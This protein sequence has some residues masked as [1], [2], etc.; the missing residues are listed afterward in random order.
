MPE[1][2]ILANEVITAAN[3]ADAMR[4][5]SSSYSDTALATKRLES[6]TKSFSN[7][8]SKAIDILDKNNLEARDLR[9]EIEDL[10]KSYLKFRREN[11]DVINS[12]RN[13]G[14]AVET[15]NKET[16]KSAYDILNSGEA[17][18][19]YARK[20]AE[21]M[22]DSES[23][24]RSFT[25]AYTDFASSLSG[26]QIMNNSLVSTYREY[27][28]T[29]DTLARS[30][31]AY[32]KS[33]D[34]IDLSIRRLGETTNLSR[35]E[36]ADIYATVERGMVGMRNYEAIDGLIERIAKLGHNA[37]QTK[38]MIQ[39]TMN[40][41]SKFG[42]TN[43]SSLTFKE[44]MSLSREDYMNAL[45]VQEGR[46]E[47]FKSKTGDFLET[48]QA[49]KKRFDDMKMGMGETI[50]GA[51]SSMPGGATG[52]VGLVGALAVLTQ[53]LRAKSLREGLSG[54]VTFNEAAMAKQ[55]EATAV[56]NAATLKDTQ[57]K[58]A[59]AEVTRRTTTA[60]AALGLAAEK[61]AA[62]LTGSGGIGARS[63]PAVLPP[64]S[65]PTTTM[66]ENKALQASN[67]SMDAANLQMQNSQTES[68]NT[69][70]M[71]GVEQGILKSSL[72]IEQGTAKLASGGKFSG[73]INS[74]MGGGG[75]FGNN[76]AMFA[77]AMAMMLPMVASMLTKQM[78]VSK[79]TA[80]K[81][82]SA[83]Q[84]TMIAGMVSTAIIPFLPPKAKAY[85]GAASAVAMGV[86]AIAGW[87]MG[88][89]KN[90][91][92]AAETQRQKEVN[93][94]TLQREEIVAKVSRGESTVEGIRGDITKNV[95]EYNS[96]LAEGEP[97]LSV[98]SVLLSAL[99]DKAAQMQIIQERVNNILNTRISLDTELLNIGR[100][101]TMNAS[102]SIQ[103]SQDI[104]KSKEMEYTK[105][106]EMAADQISFLQQ[107]QQVYQATLKEREGLSGRTDLSEEEKQTE[108]ERLDGKI[109]S[110]ETDAKAI[111][112]DL[113]KAEIGNIN[114]DLGKKAY[115]LEKSRNDAALSGVRTKQEGIKLDTE[116]AEANERLSQASHMGMGA[117]VGFMQ[118]T[119]NQY[120][121]G[122][123]SGMEAIGEMKARQQ[124]LNAEIQKGGLTEQEIKAK[125]M[126][127][128]KL[129]RDIQKEQISI[130]NQR[131][132]GL[133]KMNTLRDKYV[134]ALPEVGFAGFSFDFDVSKDKGLSLFTGQGWKSPLVGGTRGGGAATPTGGYSAGGYGGAG[135]MGMDLR[136][137][138]ASP[139]QET[140][141]R[142]MY[143]SGG[144]IAGEN[145]YVPIIGHGG[146]F[147]VSPENKGNIKK[148]NANKNSK[149]NDVFSNMVSLK[150][151]GSVPFVDQGYLAGGENEP[152]P[153]YA[154]SGS[155]MLNKKEVEGGM[156]TS[157]LIKGKQAP[158]ISRSG[159]LFSSKNVKGYAEGS[160][161][162]GP[163]GRGNLDVLNSFSG[164]KEFWDTGGYNI[165]TEEN[166]KNTIAGSLTDVIVNLGGY[167]L[168]KRVGKNQILSN[169]EQ[170]TEYIIRLAKKGKPIPENLVTM[171]EQHMGSDMHRIGQLNAR[172]GIEGVELSTISSNLSGSLE[173]EEGIY[174]KLKSKP[175]TGMERIRAFRKGLTPEQVIKQFRST[176]GKVL[177]DD[178]PL[179][180]RLSL[181]RLNPNSYENT[182]NSLFKSEKGVRQLFKGWGSPQIE[183]YLESIEKAGGKIPPNLLNNVDSM[184]QK[185]FIAEGMSAEQASALSL[186]NFF[187][188][189][190][191]NLLFKNGEAI[192]TINPM[193]Y[194]RGA[195]SGVGGII[196]KY[197]TAAMF[198]KALPAM[199]YGGIESFGDLKQAYDLYNE[200]GGFTTEKNGERA[201]KSL[202]RGIGKFA[203]AT[204]GTMAGAS[205]GA[206]IGTM[207]LPGLGTVVG[208]IIGSIAGGMAGTS[209]GGWVGEKVEEGVKGLGGLAHSAWDGT[210]ERAHSLKDSAEDIIYEH[211]SGGI[212]ADYYT[213]DH[214]GTGK[215][216][217]N[218]SEKS[219]QEAERKN[220]EAKRG[221]ASS[222]PV[223][224]ESIEEL[225]RNSHQ[226]AD[227]AIEK[228]EQE[229]DKS[230]LINERILRNKSLY[231]ENL[232][233]LDAIGKEKLN[234]E[235]L[236]ID[237]S[238]KALSSARNRRSKLENPSEGKL[239]PEQ[240]KA[241]INYNNPEVEAVKKAKDDAEFEERVA[242]EIAR[243]KPEQD[244]MNSAK[245]ENLRVEKKKRD[246]E[247]K[248]QFLNTPEGQAFSVALLGKNL[249]TPQQDEA[250]V[251]RAITGGSVKKVDE[252]KLFDKNQEMVY[253]IEL[254][255]LNGKIQELRDKADALYYPPENKKETDEEK[256][257][258]NKKRG[259]LN[260]EIYSL[261]PRIKYLELSPEAK[262]AYEKE[263]TDV[264]SFLKPPK[265]F[266]F[267]GDPL[268]KEPTLEAT[269]RADLTQR[270]QMAKVGVAKVPTAEDV[271]LAKQALSE[272][273]L[274]PARAQ[275]LA[276]QATLSIDKTVKEKRIEAA[277]AKVPAAPVSIEAL[278]K[279]YDELEGEVKA[280]K[281]ESLL[282]T[283]V[284]IAQNILSNKQSTKEQKLEAQAKLAVD[285]NLKEKQAAAAA[286]STQIGNARLEEI[287]IEKNANW[288]K[289]NPAAAAVKK[290]GIDPSKWDYTYYVGWQKELEKSELEKDRKSEINNYME[291]YRQ[292][293]PNQF[294]KDNLNIQVGSIPNA[295]FFDP[296]KTSK[297]SI[298]PEIVNIHGK[299]FIFNGPEDG[300]RSVEEQAR[301]NQERFIHTLDQVTHGPKYDRFDTFENDQEKLKIFDNLRTNPDMDP[302]D[303][304]YATT[305]D[306]DLN[307]LVKRE[308]FSFGVRRLRSGPI[309]KFTYFRG[310]KQAGNMWMAAEAEAERGIQK[311]YY[312]DIQSA[313]R[314]KSDE[315]QR[316]IY[317]EWENRLSN[318][319]RMGRNRRLQ[320]YATGGV[321]KL[322]DSMLTDGGIL[323]VL[324]PNEVVLNKG[325]VQEL[326]LSSKDFKQVG[327]PGFESGGATSSFASSM[328][329]SGGGRGGSMMTKLLCSQCQASLIEDS[330]V[331][332]VTTMVGGGLSPNTEYSSKSSSL[333]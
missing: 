135:S 262:L 318:S 205:A 154:K 197:G 269:V 296:Y 92:D 265:P 86:G 327:V 288:V 61:T 156:L 26:N 91:T 217:G 125:S 131:I 222:K 320:F 11:D 170:L 149:S 77:P 37:E 172:F 322:E 142:S 32:G 190:S 51:I 331:S 127:S 209:V 151:G 55:R 74:A 8:L 50:G 216:S 297:K 175:V 42:T 167:E 22:K 324:H 295:P 159:E 184:L 140:V 185:N 138:N 106:K 299:K 201:S 192:K 63:L 214:T 266:E 70:T 311:N 60:T 46:P 35:K 249:S 40:V 27:A 98:S 82:D 113:K 69:Q 325:Q 252:K 230:F 121:R 62:K 173:K 199:V 148:Y 213:E 39:S 321:T 275:K 287:K 198:K 178:T 250:I 164:I 168:L 7:S 293:F 280:S 196:T 330:V 79:E 18:G 88:D 118:E 220:L 66:S 165:N 130:Q 260:E 306:P 133:E 112:L 56:V 41:M 274:N 218:Y 328:V 141:G 150:T 276:A 208:S 68:R 211:M 258:R 122:I 316:G 132:K 200:T 10:E 212:N 53:A 315:E 228:E 2:N 181:G 76:F 24:L 80:T 129:D 221:P 94:L 271:A 5:V 95:E 298:S 73:M 28:G 243:R 272:D 203:G 204:S 237:T 104:V 189:N 64:M 179:L 233:K 263:K 312:S 231:G 103:A 259:K 116:L 29:I 45:N 93:R 158:I 281:I 58:T 256:N 48:A 87:M 294:K 183:N 34:S 134:N 268:P 278:Q 292:T 44:T 210:V 326:G 187:P 240:V 193:T 111:G 255:E 110:F 117:E 191:R 124:Q 313:T 246:A 182:L 241:L 166:E 16:Q 162:L 302:P 152:F 143:K 38:S 30:T 75:N 119:M 57:I 254:K 139:S 225:R 180:R 144:D 309:N 207:I 52:A 71:V 236:N 242:N 227:D 224:P 177:L 219:L 47:N 307:K 238:D 206:L 65:V 85:A 226:L 99:R 314:G 310:G 33:A 329:G 54:Q 282:P 14:I 270:E 234:K 300:V 25:S 123:R 283:E 317:Q 115:E 289:E 305:N 146:E 17:W 301:I 176:Q 223:K 215:Y 4:R 9:I 114:I 97:K 72:N 83:A 286:V 188:G 67:I 102:D 126:A 186:K 304:F 277:A 308:I 332:G 15:L 96:K 284:I 285:K 161:Y 253:D 257:V 120:K 174:K 264:D 291:A 202:S 19:G 23:A 157:D 333:I 89:K 31:M 3:L 171:L 267:V 6:D 137:G 21:S 136:M 109:K 105:S 169:P 303:D 1:D 100:T 49:S 194:L 78:G 248:K 160:S 239:I 128:E 153:M 244:K 279:T 195:K 235:L 247:I 232:E 101:E 145:D 155:Y 319:N 261:R 147:L 108:K 323:S 245:A 59:Q 81:V 84:G 107:N 290:Q 273:N 163:I 36:L 229:K 251:R 13:M 90:E 20:V 43:V 12:L